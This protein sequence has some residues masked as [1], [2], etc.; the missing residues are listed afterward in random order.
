MKTLLDKVRDKLRARKGA[1]L[2]A[3]AEDSGVSYDT[4]LRIRDAERQ[5]PPYDPGFSRVQKLA[6]HFKLVRAR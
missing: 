6:E 1:Q 5:C 4:L 3:V 2:L